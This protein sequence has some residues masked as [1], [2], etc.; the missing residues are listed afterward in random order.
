MK[1]NSCSC[2]YWHWKVVPKI[3]IPSCLRFVRACQILVVL[4]APTRYS[5]SH[6]HIF[7][8]HDVI[9]LPSSYLLHLVV[10]HWVLLL[11]LL[12]R[13]SL[14]RIKIWI[15]VNLYWI[16]LFRTKE[17]PNTITQPLNIGILAVKHLPRCSRQQWPHGAVHRAVLLRQSHE[18]PAGR[19]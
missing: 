9:F 10:L 3:W 18:A 16:S 2:S 6:H 11:L 4:T 7:I 12:N 1:P 19:N 13:V 8:S 5:I 14:S 17:S 15:E